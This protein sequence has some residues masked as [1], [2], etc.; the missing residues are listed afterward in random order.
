M[1]ELKILP[2]FSSTFNILNSL[3]Y[4]DEDYSDDDDDDDDIIF[5]RLL[6]SVRS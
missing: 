6:Y 3:G 2:N 4:N 1:P 5:V